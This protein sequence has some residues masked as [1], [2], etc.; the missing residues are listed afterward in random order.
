MASGVVV[1]T[2]LMTP[3]LADLRSTHTYGQ[4]SISAIRESASQASLG[5]ALNELGGS[6]EIVATTLRDIP[7]K[8]PYRFGATYLMYLRAIVPNPGLQRRSAEDVHGKGALEE[9]MLNVPPHEWASIKILGIDNALYRGEG[10]GFSAVAEPYFN[11]GYFGVVVFFLLLGVFL[12][13]MEITHLLLDYPWLLFASIF[14]WLLLPTVR[15]DLGVFTKPAS[16]VVTSIAIWL[17]VRRF[18]PWTSRQ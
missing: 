2:L 1:L 4:I 16:F 7:A 15:N 10:V 18:T 14:Y 17:L 8:E 6:V 3:V 12:A 11:F 9:G 5:S 13:R